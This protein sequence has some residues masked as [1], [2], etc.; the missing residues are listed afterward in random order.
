MKQSRIDRTGDA[1]TPET[2]TPGAPNRWPAGSTA[3][4]ALTGGALALPGISGP[5]WADAA[6]QKPQVAGSYSYYKEDSVPSS[7]VAVGDTDRYEIHVGQLQAAFPIADDKDLSVDFVVEH[8]SGASPWSVVPNPEKS[9]ELQL[10]MSGASIEDTRFD[11]LITGNFYNPLGKSSLSGGFSIEDDY[12]SVNVGASIERSFQSRMTTL[13]GGLGI[14]MDEIDPVNEHVFPPGS[15]YD[16]RDKDYKQ[17]YTV[18]AGISRI[19]NRNTIFQTSLTYNHSRGN[20]DDPYKLVFFLDDLELRSDARPGSRHQL[21]W[22]TRLR[23]HSPRFHG[24]LH[25]DYQFY[26]DSW[27][28]QSHTAEVAWYQD[29]LD[30]ATLV[31]SM[32]YYT[33]NEADFY[34]PYFDTKPDISHYSSDYRLSSFGALGFRAKLQSRVFDLRYLTLQGSVGYERYIADADY[35]IDSSRYPDNPGLVRYHLFSV[36]VTG[37]F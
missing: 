13:S 18:N 20:L 12:R 26:I 25:L 34:A 33:Q 32:R 5:A 16:T 9:N 28:I 37:R 24:T 4:R 6:I 2:A 22:L 8:M 23:R 29:I 3:L 31:G 36:G 21:S 14:S 27:D 17:S 1:C 7:K 10:Y 19:I 15:T 30:W 11:T 35:A